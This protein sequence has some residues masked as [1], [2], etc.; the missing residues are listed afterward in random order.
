MVVVA[1]NF[2]AEV[3]GES[4]NAFHDVLQGA[5]I[6]DR[7]AHPD[8]K[9]KNGQQ[10]EDQDFHSHSVWNGRSRVLGMDAYGVECRQHNPAKDMI[11]E[12]RERKLLHAISIKMEFVE[13]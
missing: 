13:L 1:D 4:F 5:G 8:E 11:Q 10:N 7:Q 6:I 12:L 9:E 2:F 3:V